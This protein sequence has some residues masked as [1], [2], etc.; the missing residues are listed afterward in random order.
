MLQP[1]DRAPPPV[2]IPIADLLQRWPNL[3]Q[4]FISHRMACIGCDFSKFHSLEDAMKIYPKHAETFLKAL[5]HGLE[6]S[7]FQ[8]TPEP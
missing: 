7:R 3:A 2:D 8:D 1:I 6:T 4:V 5:T